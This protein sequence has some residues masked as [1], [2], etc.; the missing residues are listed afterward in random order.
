MSIIQDIRD[1]YA[2][3]TVVLIALALLGFVLTD[4]FQSQNRSGGG[5]TSNSLGSV[6][7]KSIDIN[8]FNSRVSQFEQQFK[9]QGY[10]AEMASSQARNQA[11]ENEIGR[12]LVDQEAS[13]LGIIVTKTELGDLLYGENPPADL[14]QQF[15]DSTGKYN[16]SAAKQTIEQILKMKPKNEQELAQKN[17][18]E[19][20]IAGNAE[21]RRQEKFFS[22]FGNSTNVPRWY[23][24]KQNADNSQMARIS[25]VKEFYTSIPDSTIKI[26]D[27]AIA[28]YIG[29]HKEDYKQEETR[30]IAYVAFSASP[31]KE[32]S[33]DAVKKLEELRTEFAT[34]TDMKT[35]L[36]RQGANYYEGYISGKTIQ[37]PV[38]DSIFRTP[39]GGVYG[40]YLDGGSFVLA[41]M[42]G[43]KTQPD[44]VKVRHILIGTQQRDEATAK[45]L[46]DSIAAVIKNGTPFD[47]VVA[48][49]EDNP[50]AENPQ[51]GKYKGGIYDRVTPGQ[52]VPSFNDFIFGNPTGAKGV[53]KTD[54]GFHYVEVMSQKGS[55]PAYKIAQLPAEIV[56]SQTTDNAAQDKANAFFADSRNAKGFDEIYEKKLKAT[57]AQKLLAS[58]IRP[59]DVSVGM[60]GSSRD[61]VKAIYNAK[62]GEVLKP[63]RVGENYI[64]AL[65]T[66]AQKEGTMSVAT[67][68][69]MVE[70]LLRNQKKA[71]MLK[72]KVGTVTTLEAAAAALGGKPVEVADSLRMDATNAGLSGEKRV[73]GAA[74]RAENKGKVVNEAIEGSQGI[75]VVKVED[76]VTTPLANA[77]VVEQRKQLAEQQKQTFGNPLG[78]LRKAA[79]IKDKRA[80]RL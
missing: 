20:L 30:S 23:V 19:S 62:V 80:D 43:V 21:Q 31:S 22:L 5:R 50:D 79:T 27:K 25:Y 32:D 74:F 12:L 58:N 63:E 46:I 55:S 15:T 77:N 29:K 24:E 72:K 3:V 56:A 40:P 70:G 49:S 18:I 52:M 60:I 59:A 28:D 71:E 10:P 66:D 36:A 67:A 75:Y 7:G 38:K 47:S 48:L 34:T 4:Y 51:A 2:K 44:T 13:K 37:I 69:P 9:N 17:Y 14:K 45:K 64:V 8:D 61:L 6:N 39:V 57:G 33:A 65:V 42:E 16:A 68:R 76:V 1:K 73:L 78:A 53:V 35:F 54:Y 26:E 41:K 11:W